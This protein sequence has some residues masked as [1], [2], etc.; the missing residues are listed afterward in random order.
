MD[1]GSEGRVTRRGWQES[2]AHCQACNLHGIAT[3]AKN[4]GYRICRH[5]GHKQRRCD[6]GA[7]SLI[8]S[9]IAKAGRPPRSQTL[10]AD[11]NSVR[12]SG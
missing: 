6:E 12:V 9:A 1:R 5:A 8:E 2:A 7:P 3:R 11:F 4:A 10:E